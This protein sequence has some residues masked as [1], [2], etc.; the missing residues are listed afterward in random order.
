MQKT[1][2][3]FRQ[4]SS[5]AASAAALDFLSRKRKGLSSLGGGGL[6]LHSCLDLAGHSQE[7]LLNIGGGL[8]R[9]LEE[10]NAERVGEFLTLFR[11]NDTLARQIRLITHQQLVDVFG[12]VSINLVQPLLNIVEGFLVGHIVYDDNSVSPAIVRGCNGSESFLSGGIPDLELDGL[13]I[14]LNCS[15]FEINTNGGDVG[16]GV[17]VVCESKE[18][19]RFTD[20]GVSNKEQFEQIVAVFSIS[21]MERRNAMLEQ[22]SINSSWKRRATKHPNLHDILQSGNDLVDLE[23]EASFPLIERRKRQNKVGYNLFPSLL[24][25]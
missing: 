5:L 14:Q 17:S 10:F 20:T 2:C 7:S 21:E 15:D 11:R 13:S 22:H 1:E 4:L 12:G 19:T 25:I 8:G 9:S 18:Q 6:S 16:F 3:V 24:F 23:K